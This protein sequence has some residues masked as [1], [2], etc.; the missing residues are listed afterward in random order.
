MIVDGHQNSE[1]S[2]VFVEG[3]RGDNI[4]QDY[5]ILFIK[6]SFFTTHRGVYNFVGTLHSHPQFKTQR[7]SACGALAYARAAYGVS[8]SWRSV[9][10]ARQTE[11]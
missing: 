8:A 7:V 6:I 9:Y 3:F 4:Y 11:P 10:G 1:D 5:V 2:H